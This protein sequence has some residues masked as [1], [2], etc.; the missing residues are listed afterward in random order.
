VKET[1]VIARED[2]PGEK[3]LVAYVISGNPAG[4]APALSVE[5]LHAHLK[6]VLPTHMVPSAFVMLD[7]FPLTP[8]GKLDRRALPAPD[9]GAYVSPQYEAPQGEV[10]EIL[11][12]TWQEL[13]GVERVGREDNFFELG[14]HSL[15]A[16][17]LIGRIRSSLSIEMPMRLLF[18]FPTLRQLSAQV[19]DLRHAGLLDDIEDGANEM[20]EL[21]ERVAAMPESKV[22]D[23]VRD[24]RMRVRP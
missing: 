3:R 24:L 5:A 12:G 18:D 10:E 13:L 2:V 16:T 6:A 15:L 22:Q 17:Q 21:L 1:V 9:L 19:E 14:G 20:E 8:N 11:A 23:L 4:A 7:R